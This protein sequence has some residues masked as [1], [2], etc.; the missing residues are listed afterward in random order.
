MDEAAAA[1]AAA[2]QATAYRNAL[3]ET[4]TLYAAGTIFI[5][6]R[7]FVRTKLVGIRNYRP[8]DYLV[9]VAWA[10]YTGMTIAAH[11]VGGVGDTSHIPLEERLAMTPEQRQ[12]RSLGS[13]WFMVGWFTYITLIV[14]TSSRPRRR[15]LRLTVDTQ[16]QHA[17]SISESGQWCMG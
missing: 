7:V 12:N 17:L 2:A 13:K 14:S 3:I 10:A 1:A 15:N 8:D 5:M 16:I 9:W 4:W 6:M 11:I